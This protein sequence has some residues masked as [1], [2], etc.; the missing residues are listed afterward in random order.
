VKKR[1]EF[2]KSLEVQTGEGIPELLEPDEGK[3][4]KKLYFIVM[5][6]W[7]VKPYPDIHSPLSDPNP[8]LPVK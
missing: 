7:D 2:I 5:H 4:Q 6:D 1:L 8:I 3:S